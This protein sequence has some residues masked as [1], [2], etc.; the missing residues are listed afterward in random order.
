MLMRLELDLTFLAWN[1]R[2]GQDAQQNVMR[3]INFVT[4]NI[5][6][7]P[8]LV[9]LRICI[10]GS[11]LAFD[12]I[13]GI[14]AFTIKAVLASNASLNQIIPKTFLMR[15]EQRCKHATRTWFGKSSVIP[16]ARILA[17]LDT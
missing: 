4:Q 3:H 5:A 12:I 14:P 8:S 15:G 13:I 16:S 11:R 17:T 2:G 1:D 9:C 10:T 7:Q 6:F